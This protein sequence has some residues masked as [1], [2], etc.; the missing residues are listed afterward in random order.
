MSGG[1]AQLQAVFGLGLVPVGTAAGRLEPGALATATAPWTPF[2]SSSSEKTSEG[3]EGIGCVTDL[4][5]SETP[6]SEGC[7]RCVTAEGGGG[8]ATS[9]TTVL[10]GEVVAHEAR[11][12]A[13]AKAVASD[14]RWKPSGTEPMKRGTRAPSID[15]DG[16]DL[17]AHAERKWNAGFRGLLAAEVRFALTARG[18]TPPADPGG[19]RHRAQ[20]GAAA[21]ALRVS[22]AGPRAH[23]CLHVAVRAFDNVRQFEPSLH[24]VSLSHEA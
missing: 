14:G 23:R 20:T 17:L 13:N 6:S 18:A 16:A 11:P 10:D 15:G 3:G 19:H 12:S 2:S 22:R 5:S 8:A 9:E 4:R 24:S 1:N 21:R 7:D